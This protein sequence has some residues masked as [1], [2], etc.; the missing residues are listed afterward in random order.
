MMGSLWPQN[1]SFLSFLWNY[2]IWE[3]IMLVL[4]IYFNLD[5]TINFVG[6]IEM[7]SGYGLEEFVLNFLERIQYVLIE[8]ETVVFVILIFLGVL[9]CF[10]GYKLFRFYLGLMGAAMGCILALILVYFLKLENSATTIGIIL[11]FTG[12]GAVTM[13]FLYHLGIF[14]LGGSI[15]L[16]SVYLYSEVMSPIL[17][18][19]PYII[20]FILIGVVALLLEKHVIIIYTAMSGAFLAAY[21]SLEYYMTKNLMDP[22]LVLYQIVSRTQDKEIDKQYVMQFLA[23]GIILAIGGLFVQYRSKRKDPV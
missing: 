8:N 9:Q 23:V 11:V 1:L 2:I 4:T 21:Y 6:G 19:A 18:E 16:F 22:N 14:I 10:F 15:G 13:I 17:S 20:G 3:S 12:L 7:T 5:C